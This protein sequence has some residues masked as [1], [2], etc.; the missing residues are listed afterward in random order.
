VHHLA[1]PQPLC[2]ALALWLQLR[3]LSFTPRGQL[4][5]AQ[6]G[7]IENSLVGMFFCIQM[8]FLC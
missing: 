7:S 1:A 6:A 4:C 5:L 3:A 8:E 2:T